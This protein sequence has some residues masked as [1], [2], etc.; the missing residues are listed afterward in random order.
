MR[1]FRPV[2]LTQAPLMAARE[3]QLATGCAVGAELVG[4]ELV[5]RVALLLEQFAHEPQ[6]SLGVA[7]GLDQQV[8]HLAFAIDGSPQIH[9]PALDR[10]HQLVQVPLA[11]WSWPQPAQVAGEGGS[12]LQDPAPDRLVGGLDAPLRQ[13]LLDIAVAQRE[14]EIEPGCMPDD[15]GRELVAGIGDG[16]HR[17]ALS[18]IAPTRPPCRDNA[19]WITS[20]HWLASV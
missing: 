4:R 9:T 18:R 1:V 14:P 16:L 11:R 17:A 13:E 12:E 10:D 20:R 2:V 19:R 5:W 15:L 6:G 8:Q 7:L 3:T